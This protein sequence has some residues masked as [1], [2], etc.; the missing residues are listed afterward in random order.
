MRLVTN[1]AL[2]VLLVVPTL[3]ATANV[4]AV[5]AQYPTIQSAVN[6][7]QSGDTV[8][9]W[10]KVDGTPYKEFVH[11]GTAGV[12][13]EG[14]H[15]PVMDGTGLGTPNP[16]SPTGI[17]ADNGVTVEADSATVCGFTIQNY[18][19]YVNVG[20]I[21]HLAAGVFVSQRV[22]S[23]VHDNTLLTNGIGLYIDGLFNSAV[24][25]THNVTDNWISGNLSAGAFLFGTDG[26]LIFTHNEIANNL[27][28]GVAA[29]S[30]NGLK[31]RHNDVYGNSA[32]NMDAGIHVDSGGTLGGGSGTPSV[33]EDNN[34]YSNMG[35]GIYVSLSSEQAVSHNTLNQNLTG[36]VVDFCTNVNVAHNSVYH[37][38]TDG[39]VLFDF[40]VN[41]TVA[42]NESDSNAGIG[43]HIEEISGGLD[44]V[45]N[46]ISNNKASGNV[47][48]DAQDD[49]LLYSILN[50]A[51]TWSKNQFGTMK[52]KNLPN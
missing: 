20:A 11:I 37:S 45:G 27:G 7:A 29:E 26:D 15:D 6:A 13:L 4:L 44:T 16:N 28:T 42:F 24:P 49:S 50:P 35:A 18:Q 9:V 21:P 19:N 52:P 43:F 46:I 14:I 30:A 40:T 39:V 25:Q 41:C 34:V 10:P 38:S 2:A 5:P 32:V 17:F 51:N 22:T 12:R 33:V 8:R 48:A 36:I 1:L 31:L 3:A 47:I 23:D